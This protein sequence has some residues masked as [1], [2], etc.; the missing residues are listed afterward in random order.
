MKNKI[1]N[2]GKGRRPSLK[3]NVT[4]TDESE[5][6]NGDE[7]E[8]DDDEEDEEFE[9]DDNEHGGGAGA[10]RKEKRNKFR[11]RKNQVVIYEEPK[12]VV[13]TAQEGKLKEELQ[14]LRFH[15]EDLKDVGYGERKILRGIRK[16]LRGEAL[17]IY[18][19]T[20]DEAKITE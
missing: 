12:P 6:T 19:K 1:K 10:V 9:K 13:V 7:E 14:N 16:C 11:E 20:L 2:S 4:F 17:D 15:I 18:T 8:E 3:R 5:G